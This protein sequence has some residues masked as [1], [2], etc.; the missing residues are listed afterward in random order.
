MAPNGRWLKLNHQDIGN[1]VIAGTG[2]DITDFKHKEK[3]LKRA[4]TAQSKLIQD[5][6]YG[7]LVI[8][9]D[10]L[11]TLFNPAYQDY[12]RSL[13]FEV[14]YGMHTKELTQ[15]F[16][17]AKAIDIEIEDFNSWFKEFYETRFGTDKGLVEE[18][19]LRDG[20]HILRH[21]NYR[22]LVGNIITITDITEIKN[23]QLNAE[24][25]E[26]SKAEFLANMSH[27]IRTPMNGVMGMACLLYTSPSPRDLS[28]S[29]MPSSA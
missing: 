25:A 21:Q 10:G 23:A 13:G 5:L 1:G 6:K 15:S 9:D 18:F 8:D 16:L 20:R 29:R 26:R 28:T 19:S 11:I 2:F 17:D 12:C 4:K 14:Y 3:D 22:K 27:E 7:L 24:A